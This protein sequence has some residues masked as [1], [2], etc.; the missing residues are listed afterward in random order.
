M[1]V[2]GARPSPRTSGWRAGAAARVARVLV[3]G[4]MLWKGQGS[5]SAPQLEWFADSGREMFRESLRLRLNQ[6]HRRLVRF[7]KVHPA[8]SHQRVVS[9]APDSGGR[10]AGCGAALEICARHPARV[11]WTPGICARRR[12]ASDSTHACSAASAKVGAYLL[13][14]EN[15]VPT[16][17]VMAFQVAPMQ[18]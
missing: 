15:A 1:L 6:R 9:R 8:H 2:C 10:A 18:R 5:F 7:H 17:G 14:V 4:T 16:P 3:R 13:D 12:T 11:P